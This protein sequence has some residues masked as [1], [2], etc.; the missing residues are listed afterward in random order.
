[1]ILEIGQVVSLQTK[2]QHGQIDFVKKKDTGMRIIQY[3]QPYGFD[4]VERG[5]GLLV[6]NYGSF[7]SPI[8]ELEMKNSSRK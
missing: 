7:A 4:I 8:A 2:L 5:G 6:A 3:L 1:M